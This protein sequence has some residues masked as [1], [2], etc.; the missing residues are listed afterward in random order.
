MNQ[1]GLFVYLY[2]GTVVPVRYTRGWGTVVPAADSPNSNIALLV[3]V[4]GKAVTGWG[5]KHSAE[6]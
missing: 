4:H 6:Q 2:P 1:N 5:E 3:W